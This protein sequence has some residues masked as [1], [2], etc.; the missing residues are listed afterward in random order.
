MIDNQRK[1]IEFNGAFSFRN[2]L[3]ETSRCVQS[4]P[5]P[6][7]SSR[8]VGIQLNSSLKFAISFSEF[9]I[10]RKECVTQSRMRFSKCFIKLERFTSHRLC[11]WQSFARRKDG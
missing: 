4:L 11:L 2:R 6:L 8:K 3:I 5:A 7:M 1:G 9:P 10:I